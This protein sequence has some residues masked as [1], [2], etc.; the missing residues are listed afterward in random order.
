MASCSSLVITL[1]LDGTT[2]A[3]P[4]AADASANMTDDH[5]VIALSLGRGALLACAISDASPTEGDRRTRCTL[6]YLPC[7][8]TT[9]FRC[10]FTAEGLN[11]VKRFSAAPQGGGVGLRHAHHVERDDG[12]EGG[13]EALRRRYDRREKCLAVLEGGELV[14]GEP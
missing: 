10:W 1:S 4:A 5:A 13:A 11:Q 2:G 6:V 7:C 8:I 9:E 14:L 3:L 12:V